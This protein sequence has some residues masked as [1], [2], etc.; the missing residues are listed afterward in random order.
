MIFGPARVGYAPMDANVQPEPEPI[1][2][3]RVDPTT[4]YELEELARTAN[5]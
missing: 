3:A 1:A 4:G 2:P 5:S